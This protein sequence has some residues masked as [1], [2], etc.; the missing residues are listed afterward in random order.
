[1]RDKLLSISDC[2]KKT[3]DDFL[4]DICEVLAL[5]LATDD[6]PIV[7]RSKI[8][9]MSSIQDCEH[10]GRRLSK[11]VML[12]REGRPPTGNLPS[13]SRATPGNILSAIVWA[14]NNE[15]WDS[16]GDAVHLGLVKVRS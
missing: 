6:P 14:S 15:R 3:L 12:S 4:L 7:C 1:M 13:V 2:F 8:D 5:E 9:T 11:L 10:S 16:I